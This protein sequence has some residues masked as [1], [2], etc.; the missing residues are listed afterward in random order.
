MMYRRFG[1][2][3]SRLL[4]YKQDQ[5]RRLE[6][7]LLN[8]DR[9][10]DELEETQRCLKSQEEGEERDEDIEDCPTRADKMQ[11]LEKKL[12]EY[13]NLMKQARDL[14]GMN[15]PSRRDHNSVSNYFYNQAPL[16]APDAEFLQHKEDLISIRP[17]REHAWL[18]DC[19]D[20]MLRWYPC[21]PVKYIFCDEVTLM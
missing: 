4:L 10:D 1:Q 3:H 13:G 19:V 21:K 16:A 17:G 14:H 11:E 5:I 15:R 9:L 18:D 12:L 20:A 6:D 8:L 2:L 7:D